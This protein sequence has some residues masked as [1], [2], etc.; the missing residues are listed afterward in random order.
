MALAEAIKTKE[1]S[2]TVE[3]AMNALLSK[4]DEA[5]DDVEH[6]R[7]L[8]DLLFYIVDDKLS[9]VTILRVL[10][11]GMNWQYILKRWIREQDM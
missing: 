5:I 7:V 6:G 8:D 11:D 2:Y 4:L 1:N 9:V 10:K 3:N